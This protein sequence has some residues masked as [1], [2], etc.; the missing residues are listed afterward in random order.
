[1][2]QQSMTPAEL[3]LTLTRMARL[4]NAGAV[5]AYAM[6]Q[7][8]G[9][10]PRLAAS[11]RAMDR[12]WTEAL[13][14]VAPVA[15]WGRDY[16]STASLLARFGARAGLDAH[17]MAQMRGRALDD[18]VTQL[19]VQSTRPA[20]SSTP[21]YEYDVTHIVYEIWPRVKELGRRE[22]SR[23]CLIQEPPYAVPS[24]WATRCAAASE[25]LDGRLQEPRQPTLRVPW[26][27][28]G[29]QDQDSVSGRIAFED[30]ERGPLEVVG[31]PRRLEEGDNA[32]RKMCLRLSDGRKIDVIA[33]RACDEGTTRTRSAADTERVSRLRAGV[34]GGTSP[35][36]E[37][38]MFV[39]DDELG[40]DHVVP[41]TVARRFEGELY[42]FQIEVENGLTCEDLEDQILLPAIEERLF[43]KLRAEKAGTEKERVASVHIYHAGLTE[44]DEEYFRYLDGELAR[45]PTV[46]RT[47]LLDLIAAND[48]RHDANILYSLRPDG[49]VRAHAIDNGASHPR[50]GYATRRFLTPFGERGSVRENL[51][52]F[53]ED[54]NLTWRLQSIDT[55]RLL[56]RWRNCALEP[57]AA[58]ASL[59]RLRALQRDPDLLLDHIHA[60][61]GVNPDDAIAAWLSAP[62]RDRVA[63]GHLS[64]EDAVEIQRRVE[65]AYGPQADAAVRRW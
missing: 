44:A 54:A 20:S 59:G 29:R 5:A 27:S 48:D 47:V 12:R 22:N 60:S 26:H 39:L 55:A 42:S 51:V 3:E 61:A 18:T 56:G 65:H 34:P 23:R 38:A 32:P 46:R 37:Q 28:I 21:A 49:S 35:N 7:R 30:L 4:R 10:L 24:R 6:R 52:R 33:K 13:T 41:I 45:E 58:A 62:V 11:R 16:E 25:S 63:A 31:E 36:R 15:R 53:S 57:D 43:R 50:P 19:L 40:G 8:G 2:W 17:E 9:S 64:G 1:M 14:W